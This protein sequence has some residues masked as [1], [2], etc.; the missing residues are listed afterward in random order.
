MKK[1][2]NLATLLAFA[3][4]LSCCTHH[5]KHLLQREDNIPV[6][7]SLDEGEHLTAQQAARDATS[8]MDAFFGN[9]L[10]GGERRVETVEAIGSASM[11]RAEQETNTEPLVYIVNFADNKGYAIL[12]ATQ[13]VEPIWSVC[14]VGNLDL[15]SMNVETYQQFLLEQIEV[16]Y[17]VSRYKQEHSLAIIGQTPVNDSTMAEFNDRP[18]NTQYR[19]DYGNWEIAPSTKYECLIP[20]V[21]GQTDSPYADLT[22]PTTG[23]RHAGCVTAAVAQIMAYHRYPNWYLWDLMLRHKAIS[24]PDSTYTKAFPEIARLYRDLGIKLKVRYGKE[25]SP[26]PDS[27][28]P[29][30][31]RAF[32]YRNSGYI[33]PY[34]YK[35]AKSEIKGESGIGHPMYISGCAIKYEHVKRFLLWK[36]K[37]N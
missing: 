30:T 14:P 3:S 37:K 17:N 32:K 6:A 26:A 10:R 22:K 4:I 15:S 16:S 19:Y 28:V 9:P 2:N 20:V 13:G 18:L 1:L 11:L 25:G 33:V 5:G 21:W 27:N 24:S 34:S 12:S 36:W 31:F 23:S 8:L 29:R 7:Y 35:V